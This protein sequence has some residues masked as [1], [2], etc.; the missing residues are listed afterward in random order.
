M[1]HSDELRE[2]V[3]NLDK[4]VFGSRENPKETPGVIS[5]LAQMNTI[6]MEM[7]DAM[8]RINWILITA[9][10]TALCVLVFKNAPTQ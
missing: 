3:D 1:P 6:L 8:R 7:R 2:R 9:F 5:E 10:V 4:A